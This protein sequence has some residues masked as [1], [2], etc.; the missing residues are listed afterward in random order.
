MPFFEIFLLLTAVWGIGYIFRYLRWPAIFGEILAGMILGPVF[1]DLVHETEAIKILAELGIFFL[2]LHTGLEANPQDL[3]KNSRTSLFVAFGSILLPFFGGYLVSLAFGYPFE[4]A[5][6]IG[7][8]LSITAI[9]ISAKIFKDYRISGTRVAHITFGAAIMS[10]IMGLILF[11]IALNIASSGV[12]DIS[13]ILFLTFEILIFFGLV[14]FVGQTYFARLHR[15]V[16]KG[17]KGF[18]FVIIVALAFGLLAEYI[19][20]HMIIGALLAGLF[21][22]EE[23]IEESVFQKIE[24]RLYG[25]S[26]SLLGPIFFATLAFHIDLQALGTATYFTLALT[27]VVVITKILG[28]GIAAL[29]MKL[30]KA[31]SLGIGLAMNCRGAVDLI[32]ASIGLQHGIIDEKIF[33]VLVIMA[34]VTT[35]ISIFGLKSIRKSLRTET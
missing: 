6:F 22:R 16:Y 12:I 4:Q 21:V 14:L 27:V 26:Y 19:G 1:L 5:F 30:T 10:D 7:M 25:V 20:L 17:N 9:A 11:S 8:T 3:L 15:V 2:M 33:S 24:D 23:I 32:I 29:F 34:F 18:T 28:S 31:E 13:S 35:L